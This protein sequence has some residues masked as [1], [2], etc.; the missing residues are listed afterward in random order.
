MYPY[1]DIATRPHAR[2]YTSAGFARALFAAALLWSFAA[3]SAPTTAGAPAADTVM[4][5]Q[6]DPTPAAA[7][8]FA[9]A[10]QALNAANFHAKEQAIAALV[11]LGDERTRAVLRAMQDGNLHYRKSDDKVVIVAD[12]T[13]GYALTDPLTGAALGKAGKRD[14]KKIAINNAL[15]NV[16]REAGARLSLS[17]QRADVRLAAV[18]E[19]TGNLDAAGIALLESARAKEQDDDVAEAMDTALA[20]A[21]LKSADAAA[22]RQA[23]ENLQDSLLPSVRNELTA[24]TENKSAATD[25]RAAARRAL[26]RIEGKL[27]LYALGETLFFGLS[28]GSVLL[29]AGIGLAITFG[30]MGVIN[31]A[32]GEL[33]MLGAYTTYLVQQA[34]PQSLDYSMAVAIPAAFLVSGLFGIAIERGVIRFL[35]GRP[36]ETLLATFGI[37]LV[38]QQLV[39]T[40]ISAQNVTVANPSWMSGSWQINPALALTYNRLYIVLFTLLVFAALLLLLKKTALGLHVRAV[41]QNRPMARAMGIRSDWVDAL[42]FGL[43]SGIAGVAGV[44]LSQLTNVGPNMGQA[45]IID[46]FMVVVL[47][48]VGQLAGTVYA[49]LGLGVASKLIEPH[50]GAVLTKILILVLIIAFIQKRPQGLFALKG[51]AV[52]A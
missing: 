3:V 16:L 51:R 32:H 5:A 8:D 45:Y 38:L 23:V 47:G 14:T 34:M 19:L 18:E 22:Q 25:V 26:S 7:L 20:L 35:Y 1:Q 50:I 10:V 36:L 6:T 4:V 37:S 33:I 11:Q 12:D 49:A 29:L 46:S 43:G 40:T 52:E 39:R 28:L 13:E 15:R 31:M 41:A 44:A 27:K 42:T 9:A 30:V 48:G 2:R 21:R 24:L 17:S